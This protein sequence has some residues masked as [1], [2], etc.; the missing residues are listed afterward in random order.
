MIFRK[1]TILNLALL[2]IAQL[3][4]DSALAY[5][6]TWYKTDFWAGEYPHGFTLEKDVSTQ[7]R[8]TLDPQ[9]PRTIDCAMKK[10]ATYHQ[11]NIERVVSAKLEFISYVPTVTYVIEKPAAFTLRNEQ[12]D[13]DEKITFGKGDEWIYLTYYAEGAFKMSFKGTAYSA[14]QD[15]MEASREKDTKTLAKDRFV[16]EWLKLTCA[17]GASGWL[18]SRDV[19]G[20]PPYGSP[21]FIEY[22]V[23]KDK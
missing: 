9:A 20:K 10:G 1:L 11:W 13:S 8:A 2:P 14:E 16:D 18:L 19:L 23:A 7:I 6:A 21:N 15:L 3:L 22:G 4:P 5:D 17:N 12:T